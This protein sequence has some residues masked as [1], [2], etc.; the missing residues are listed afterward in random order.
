MA[1]TEEHE[2]LHEYAGGWMTERK[3]T[4]AP[5]F[6]KF[7]YVVIAVCCLAYMAVYM[8]G[9]TGHADHGPLIE[10]FNAVTGTADTFMWI[11]IGL[12]AVMLLVLAKFAFSKVHEE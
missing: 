2:E 6:L 8:N 3:G 10:Q 9:A 12:G 5:V 4:D 11:V 7:A 1:N